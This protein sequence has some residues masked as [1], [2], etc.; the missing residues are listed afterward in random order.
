MISNYIPEQ[1]KQRV[2]LPEAIERYTGERFIK[3]KMRCP[4]HNEKTASFRVYPNGKYYCF[5]CGASGD[6]IGFVMAYFGTDYGQALRRLDGDYNLG[7]FDRPTFSQ[8]R[9]MQREAERQRK[10]RQRQK[11]RVEQLDTAYWKA[12]DKVLMLERIIEQYRPPSPDA[13]PPPEFIEALQKIEYA[14]HQLD[15]AENERRLFKQ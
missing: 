10:E 14:R 2:P 1:I 7:L 8:H 13:E 5:G 12:F 4:L 9:Q 11:E 3:N 15:C 6:V